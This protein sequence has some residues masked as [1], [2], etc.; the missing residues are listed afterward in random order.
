MWKYHI[1]IPYKTVLVKEESVS[2]VVK[3]QVNNNKGKDAIIKKYVNNL[4]RECEAMKSEQEL[5][6]NTCVQFS[7]FL[8]QSAIALYNDALGDYLHHLIA[9]ETNTKNRE[10]LRRR[11]RNHNEE[12][13]EI[14]MEVSHPDDKVKLLTSDDV[15]QLIQKLN[16]MHIFGKYLDSALA[17]TEEVEINES[18]AEEVDEMQQYNVDAQMENRQQNILISQLSFHNFA[19]NTFAFRP[20]PYRRNASNTLQ[21]CLP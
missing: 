14:D 12:V 17:V 8:K 5:I 15:V 11:L 7:I 19:S 20:N 10:D 13:K 2:N 1:Q 6:R 21:F 9:I 18:K 3:Q 4:Q 16:D